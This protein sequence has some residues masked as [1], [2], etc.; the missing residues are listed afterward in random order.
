MPIGP[1]L[2][3]TEGQPS[4]ESSC[5]HVAHSLSF[6]GEVLLDSQLLAALPALLQGGLVWDWGCPLE[7]LTGQLPCFSV[8]ICCLIA[9]V[10]PDPALLCARC[11]SAV[12]NC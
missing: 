3:H 8:E 4:H 6:S 7:L 9:D 2:C 11:C 10:K 1:I 5:H 12:M